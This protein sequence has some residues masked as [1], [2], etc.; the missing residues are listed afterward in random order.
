[1]IKTILLDLDDTIFDF[2]ACEREALS[3]ALRSFDLAFKTEDLDDYSRINE[4][5]WK[6]F[7]RGEITRE[8]LRTKRF[9][10]FLS[11]YP[12]PPDAALFADRYM[13]SLS[14]TKDLIDGAKDLLAV[15]SEKYDL[16][17][18][19][20]G[21]ERTQMGRIRA[22]GIGV[23]FKEIFISENVG[24]AK[25]KKEYFDYC[26]AH[27]KGFSIKETVLIGDSPTSDIRGGNAYGL[28]TIRYN[29][30]ALP[31]PS[32]AIPNREV[33]SLSE[34]PSLL[35]ELSSTIGE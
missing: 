22:S 19:T 27:I 28:F 34:L 2:K 23:Y 6:C 10:V 30:A 20:N 4:G 29:P 16:Y 11:R 8:E 18:V 15:L 1:M 7:E 17:A 33:R 12:S 13:Q 21:Y 32:D 24:A 5:M 35:P 3:D 25:P 9:N 14:E 31:N 26:A